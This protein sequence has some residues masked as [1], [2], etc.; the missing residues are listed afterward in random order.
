[1]ERELP[2]RILILG[3]TGVAGNTIY[4][5]FSSQNTLEIDTL[6]RTEGSTYVVDVSDS[7]ALKETLQKVKENDYDII[8]NCIGVL[9]EDAEKDPDVTYYTNSQFPKILEKTFLPTRTKIIHLSTDCVFS[10]LNGPYE[11]NRILDATTVY[12]KAKIMGE[13]NNAKDL[14]YRVSFTGEDSNLMQFAFNNESLN[15]WT[16]AYWSGF[17]SLQLAKILYENLAAPITGI[18]HLVDN[19]RS[20]SKY[21]VVKCIA[22]VY[23]LQRNIT[24][25][26]L[27][28]DLNRVLKDTRKLLDIR[29]PSYLDQ[30]TELRQFHLEDD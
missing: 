28:E 3:S 9:M 19:N 17:T 29:A 5:Y 21:E 25:V 13:I 27:K 12:G 1:M 10:G 26:T 7:N 11:E 15:G 8:L 4:R 22:E 16:N 2:M 23:G 14:T 24:P 30:F 6:S 20:I 18:Y